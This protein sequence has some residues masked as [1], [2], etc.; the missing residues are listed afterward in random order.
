M[1]QTTRPL[2]IDE[3]K[4]E[5]A[6]RGFPFDKK[7]E[8][9]GILVWPVCEAYE[10]FQKQYNYCDCQDAKDKFFRLLDNKKITIKKVE[11]A[12]LIDLFDSIEKKA[13]LIKIEIECLINFKPVE[14]HFQCISP[15]NIKNNDICILNT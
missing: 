4:A 3:F 10:A 13:S 15:H 1:E 5:M 14:E 8:S 6:L 9:F 2:K 12:R 11:M 7:T